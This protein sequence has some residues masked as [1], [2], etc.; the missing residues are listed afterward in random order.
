MGAIFLITLC[1][2]T[3]GPTSKKDVK[4]KILAK[5][6]VET[7]RDFTLNLYDEL[8]DKLIQT[9]DSKNGKFT[10]YLDL[11]KTYRIKLS[12]MCHQDKEIILDTNSPMD[13]DDQLSYQLEFNLKKAIVQR[14]IFLVKDVMKLKFCDADKKPILAFSY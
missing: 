5:G 1:S 6:V 8:S 7:E 11:N 4:I 10:V 3:P 13:V 14:D 2:W 12:Q 9:V